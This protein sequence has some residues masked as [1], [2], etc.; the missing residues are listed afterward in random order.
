MRRPIR[1]NGTR[2]G[3]RAA[4]WGTF[5]PAVFAIVMLFAGACA[6]SAVPS[7]PSNAISTAPPTT[8]PAPQP[9]AT[10]PAT[11]RATVGLTSAPTLTSTSSP[12][13]TRNTTAEN[14]PT[15]APPI[16]V[17]AQ[18]PASTPDRPFG[19]RTKDSGCIAQNGLPDSACTPG[20]VF[21]DATAAQ[22]CRSG[23]SS[24]VRDVPAEVSRMV[25]ADYGIAARSPGEFEVDHLVPLELG[26][27]NDI[28]NLW[29]QAA[30][31]PPGFHE[32]DQVANFLHAQV[33]GG[34]KNL[35]DAQRATATNWIDVYQHLPQRASATAAPTAAPA[36]MPGPAHGV[37][38]TSLTGA[39]PGGTATAVV[40]TTPGASC[41]IG[42]RTPAGT[43]STAQGLS[44]RSADTNGTVS[45]TWNIGPS[46]RPGTGTVTVTCNGESTSSPIQIS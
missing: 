7:T 1:R 24:S 33:C 34:G 39:R 14:T 6:A 40:Q 2:S 10:P 46:T 32:K 13:P 30:A 9:T 19:P 17:S 29:P 38:I 41:S 12:L 25:Y 35:I 11:A 36:P 18:Q 43:S 8:T 15:T 37:Q 5:A 27:S 3:R 45:W 44:S 16:T 42:Y 28:A 21:P 26:G 31:P 4:R 20:A 23:Y 22:I